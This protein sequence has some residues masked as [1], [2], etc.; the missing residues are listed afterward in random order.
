MDMNGRKG[1]FTLIELLVVIAIIGILAGFLLP[2]LQ[3]AKDKA[4]EANCINNLHQFLNVL[5]IYEADYETLPN[6]LSNLY[7]GYMGMRKSF[8]C[9]SDP[10]KGTEGCKPPWTLPDEE[11]GTDQEFGECDDFNGPGSGAQSADPSAYKL[12]NHDLP[13]NSY[14]YEFNPAKCS[15]WSG[16]TYSWDNVNYDTSSLGG[17]PSWRAV[18]QFELRIVGPHTPII[19][20]FWHVK[21]SGTS[22]QKVL[23]AG[24]HSRHIY[25]SS[26]SRDDW[27]YKR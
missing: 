21:Q 5:V 4:K 10:F 13:A 19:S 6:W 20:C 9:M 15:W 7:P 17:N 8:V 26:A 23:R 22:A 3:G 11:E 24:A 12:M 2:S 18:K 16:G 25:R 27:K 1:G 14:L